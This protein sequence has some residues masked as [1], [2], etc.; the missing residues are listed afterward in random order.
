M[1]TRSIYNYHGAEGILAEPCILTTPLNWNNHERMLPP[2]G[3][4][5]RIGLNTRGRFIE[6]ETGKRYPALIGV[7]QRLMGRGHSI[8]V[9]ERTFSEYR[10]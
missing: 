9:R 4:A 3:M 5:K 8:T 2:P 10:L 6:D 1:S 7:A